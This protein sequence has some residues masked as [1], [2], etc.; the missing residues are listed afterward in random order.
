MGMKFKM[1]ALAV[2]LVLLV[3]GLATAQG[4]GGPENDP[5]AFIKTAINVANNTKY[6]NVD[7]HLAIYIGPEKWAAALKDG[8][9]GPFLKLKEAKP[10][11][12][13]VFIL[14]VSKDTAVGVYFDGGT[15]F[16]MTA[17]K[18]GSNGKIEPGDISAGYKAITSEM[19][20]A[21]GKEFSF[22][23]VPINTDDGDSLTA[24]LIAKK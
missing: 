11:R 9:L 12:S 4:Q 8:D 22:E 18:A 14:S 10:G 19:L 13:A 21:T 6:Q 24:Y 2:L 23:A 5:L 20:K 7:G 15:P 17:V 16:G 1:I 3:S